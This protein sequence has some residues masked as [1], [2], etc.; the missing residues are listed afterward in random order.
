MPSNNQNNGPVNP[1]PPISI[2]FIKIDTPKQ[3]PKEEP[4]EKP[5]EEPE[6]EKEE[7]EEEEEEEEKEQEEETK[8]EEKDDEEIKEEEN[9][10]V[11][12]EIVTPLLVPEKKITSKSFFTQI[13]Q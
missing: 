13:F 11:E 3:E 6:E 8:E 1:N 10:K 2:S 5:E 9:G 7:E 4:E 12:P